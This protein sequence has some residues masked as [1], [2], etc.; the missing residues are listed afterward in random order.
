MAEALGF[1][2]QLITEIKCHFIKMFPV[3]IPF[4]RGLIIAIIKRIRKALPQEEI[5]HVLLCEDFFGNVEAKTQRDKTA[6]FE[7]SEEPCR[8]GCVS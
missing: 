5:Y 2:I 6:S 3:L 8:V 4:Y 7:N 1:I